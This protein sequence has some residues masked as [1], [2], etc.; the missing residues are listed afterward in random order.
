[1][2]TYTFIGCLQKRVICRHVNIITV[3]DKKKKYTNQE[4]KYAVPALQLKEKFGHRS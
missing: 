4:A 3:E 1:M 2:Q